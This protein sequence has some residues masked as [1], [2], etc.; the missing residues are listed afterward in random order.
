MGTWNWK[1]LNLLA[2][3][4]QTNVQKQNGEKFPDFS[5]L[6]EPS[7]AL[8]ASSSPWTTTSLLSRLSSSSAAPSSVW[9]PRLRASAVG[10]GP[11]CWYRL[12]RSRSPSP[13]WGRWVGWWPSYWRPW[14]AQKP[15]EWLLLRKWW[16]FSI[17]KI[18]SG[19][20]CGHY[21][22]KTWTWRKTFTK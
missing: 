6:L 1:L 14:R 20:S 12:P 17:L 9:P 7:A 16:Y 19:M 22:V 11:R 15:N 3:R 18:I 5:A 21:Q 10:A 4:D 13:A 8:C 2:S